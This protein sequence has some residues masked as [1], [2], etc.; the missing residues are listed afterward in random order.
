MTKKPCVYHF[1]IPLIS[2]LLIGC[3]GE[4]EVEENQPLQDQMYFETLS[5]E[6]T[7]IDFTNEIVENDSFNYMTFQYIYNGGGVAV[8]DINKDGLQDLYFTGNQVADKLYLNKGE[9]VFEDITSSALGEAAGQGW[10]TGVTMADV[11][12]DGQTDIFVSRSGMDNQGESLRNFLFINQG[13]NTFS[14]E[15]LKWGLTAERGTNQSALFDMDNDGDLDLYCMNKPYPEGEMHIAV[16]L[17]T[18]PYSDQLFENV[19]G[20]FV[21]ISKKAG[22]RNE[23]YGLGIAVSDLNHDGYIDIYISNDYVNPDFMYI[24]QGD[25]T[26]V[27]E[28]N[29]R[30]NHCSMFAMGNDVADFNNDGLVDI[31]VADMVSEDHIRSKKNMGPMSPDEFWGQVKR[32]NQMEYMFNTLQ[33]NNGNGTFSE[34]GQLAGIS[35]TDWSWATLFADFDNDGMKDLF[36]TNGYRRDVRDNDFVK[37]FNQERNLVEEIQEIHA[38]LD[39]APSTKIKNYFFQNEGN[40]H[41]SKK[42]KEWKVDDP[43]NS[44]GAA[45]ADL[46]NDGDLDLIVNNMDEVSMILENKLESKNNY[47][48]LRCEQQFIGAKVTVKA[49]G[50]QYFQEMIPTRGFQSSVE[51]VLHFGVGTHQTI[52]ELTVVFLD[53]KVIKKTNLNTNETIALNY[54]EAKQGATDKRKEQALFASVDL[55]DHTHEEFPV[56]DFD[57]EVL[58]PHKMSQLGPFISKGDANGDGLEDFYISGSIFYTGALY[59]QSAEGEFTE[60]SGPWKFQQKREEMGS[61]FFDADGDGDLDLYVVSGSN[62]YKLD[63]ESIMDQL[64]INDGKGSFKNETN[65]RLP[66]MGMSGQHVMAA[67]FDKDGDQDLFVGGRQV[68]GYYP[69]APRSFLL[70]NKDG[71]FSDITQKSPDLLGPGMITDAIWEDFDRDNDLDIVCVGEWM[72]VTF[73]ENQEGVFTNVTDRYDFKKEVGWWMSIE[74]GDFNGDGSNDYVLGNVGQ[75]NKFHPN[76]EKPL[77]IYTDDF[78]RN[79]TYD[80]VLGKYQDGKCYPV[81]GRQCSSE[82]MPFIKDKFPT[83]DEFAVADLEGIYGKRSLD[84]ALHYSA[85]NF[86]SS[87]LLSNGSNYELKK[88][89]I[90]AQFGPMNTQ[91]IL[92]VNGDGN[93]DIIAAGN[94]FGVEVETIRYDGGRGVVLLGDGN[95]NFEQLAPH[96]SGFFVNTDAKEMIRIKDWIIVAS[97]SAKIKSFKLLKVTE[98]S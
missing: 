98:A 70:E 39:R 24:N 58:L 27:D 9:M 47:I 82:Q 74:K 45:Y 55:V 18:F 72:P 94:N 26:F 62:E 35:K 71:K 43:V 41:F 73:F 68:P 11:N 54:Q 22:I 83:F 5:P 20:R 4:Q 23:G 76:H 64:Y 60:R 31:I 67:D 84:S 15:G 29:E 28:L 79:G 16:D 75:N 66:P 97:N 46:D 49:G 33:I 51:P 59:L 12:Q 2:F 88:L 63:N 52:D 7:G 78:D 69:F 95:G 6:K 80:I 91:L 34:V 85:T 3:S 57:R 87:I 48:R 8:G 93:L 13:N 81:R 90:Y 30:T 40:L 56:D 21:D 1:F 36:I 77:E 53:G 10:H 86:S 44:N 25:G 38:L 96:E 37:E 32:G 92:D 42:M 50:Q 19:G 89:P 61:T 65:D 14:E 17:D